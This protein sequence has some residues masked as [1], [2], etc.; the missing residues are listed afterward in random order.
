[1]VIDRSASPSTSN[2]KRLQP[3]K[4]SDVTSISTTAPVSVGSLLVASKRV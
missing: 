2:E 4:P 1:M 3:L